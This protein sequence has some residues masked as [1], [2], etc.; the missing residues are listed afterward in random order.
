MAIK[1]P[2]TPVAR[3]TYIAL[4]YRYL[5][6]MRIL[7]IEDEPKVAA[8]IKQGLAIQARGGGWRQ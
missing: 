5:H 3:L 8:F 7:V 4:K 2:L 1:I 6:L